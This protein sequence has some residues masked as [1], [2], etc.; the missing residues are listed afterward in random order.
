MQALK[1]ISSH[2]D[3]KGNPAVSLA[4]AIEKIFT[5]AQVCTSCADACLAE[6]MTP[7]LKQCI[8]T[9]LDCA[10]I[11]TA[12]AKVATRRTGSNEAMIRQMLEACENACRL[13]AEECEKHAEMH[14]HCR[15]CAQSCRDCE[16]ACQAA[17][18]D[19]G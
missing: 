19:V 2:P 15:I 7:E 12:A 8:R 14:E 5:C 1:I 11:C 13:C 3:V 17:L 18:K 4:D 16:S 9:D 10:D 6:E